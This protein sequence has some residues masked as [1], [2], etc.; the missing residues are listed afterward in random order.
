MHTKRNS[1]VFRHGMPEGP[2]YGVQSTSKDGIIFPDPFK[3]GIRR[4]QN[5]KIFMSQRHDLV[6]WVA[7]HPQE[8]RRRLMAQFWAKDIVVT[9]YEADLEL[10]LEQ[11]ASK[12]SDQGVAVYKFLISCAEINKFPPSEAAGTIEALVMHLRH[13][14]HEVCY[15]YY[16][17]LPLSKFW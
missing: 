4:I 14:M 3:P 7:A 13:H 11:F 17:N 8:T 1:D 12:Y 15:Q 9:I 6:F 5:A 2:F 16:E 10:T